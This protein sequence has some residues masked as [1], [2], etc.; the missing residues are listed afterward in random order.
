M[1]RDSVPE[2]CSAF[3]ARHDSRSR[4][5]GSLALRVQFLTQGVQDIRDSRAPRPGLKRQ[6]Q[7][8]LIFDFRHELR[9]TF[10]NAHFYFHDG[11][12]DLLV[13]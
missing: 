10:P 1:N 4:G 5:A 6:M 12:D 2:G 7:Q 9:L 13:C 3:L 11:H 8:V